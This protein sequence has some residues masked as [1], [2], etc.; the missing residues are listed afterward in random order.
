VGSDQINFLDVLFR[1]TGINRNISTLSLKCFSYSKGATLE[2]IFSNVRDIIS[3]LSI[4]VSSRFSRDA[5]LEEKSSLGAF[6]GVD[7]I[8]FATFDES[9]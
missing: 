6:V 8:W 1:K 9:L 3:S 7:K 2:R 4:A 5:N